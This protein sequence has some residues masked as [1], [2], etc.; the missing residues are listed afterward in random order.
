VW[1]LAFQLA[2]GEG[3]FNPSGENPAGEKLSA[4]GYR[5]DSPSPADSR[6]SPSLAS[7]SNTRNPTPTTIAESA[8][9]KSGQE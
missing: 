4:E 2:D 5:F 7:N 6:C 3:N 9:L 8:T 1:I